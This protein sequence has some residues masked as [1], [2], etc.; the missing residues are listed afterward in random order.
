MSDRFRSRGGFKRSA[1]L[2][3]WVSPAQQGYLAV[4]SA[5]ATIIS[6]APFEDPA[7]LMRSRGQISVRP[8]SF[9]A[10]LEVV[11]AYGEGIVSQEALAAGILSLPEPFSDADWG[12]WYIWRA[13]SFR[14]EF[15][16]DGSLFPASI[17]MDIDSKAMRKIAPN[18]AFVAI[19]ESFVGAFSISAPIRA[20]I[21]LP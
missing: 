9:G 20:L 16:T 2:T 11:G 21:K 17:Q 7:T 6:S 4:A 12:G 19:A 5:G 18:E 1:R 10:D 13:F 3:N 14:F 8:A 15:D